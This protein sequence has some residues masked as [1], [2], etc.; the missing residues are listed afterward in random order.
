MI[1]LDRVA[2]FL[3]ERL[4]FAKLA[5]LILWVCY[6]GSILLGDGR[7]TFNLRGELACADHLAFY[8]AARL[9]REGQPEKVYDN[10]F[11]SQYQ[12]DMFP[13]RW[14]SLEAFRNPPFYAL[15]YYPTAGWPYQASAWFWAAVSAAALAVGVWWL[16]SA[17]GTGRLCSPNG[18]TDNSQGCQPLGPTPT[19]ASPNGAADAGPVAP[20]GLNEG[21][22]IDQGLTPLAIH[23]RPVGATEECGPAARLPFLPTLVWVISF[24]PVFCALSYGQNTPLSFA[25][26]AGTY[27]L[28]AAGRPFAAG[29]AA[30]LL[31]FK[32]TLLLGLIV[33]GLL[34]IRRLW[35]AAVG[36]VVTGA[37]LTLGSYP[38]VPELWTGFIRTLGE[39]A[40]YDN[41]EQWKMHNPLAFFRLL[42]PGLD[43]RWR[44]RLAAA[45]SLAV[46]GLFVR[47]WVRRRDDLP[48]VFGG[49]VFLTLLASPHALIYEWAL[50][51]I[52]GV[53]WWPET[54]RAP[55]R[56]FVVYVVVWVTMFLATHFSE[57]QAA[58]SPVVVQVSVP[59]LGWAFWQSVRLFRAAAPAPAGLAAAPAVVGKEGA[60]APAGPG[61]PGPAP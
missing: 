59:V 48:A 50:L 38:V 46:V 31:W 42:L 27:R 61:E 7:G 51:A 56:W 18:A 16:V 11:V 12:H 29:L 53:L 44:W 43:D 17:P 4:I 19:S 21:G 14:N 35:P 28:L 49:V 20:P 47:L 30:G 52:T 32:P 6:T 33:W 2:A 36:A 8:T 55:D 60:A 34:D 58:V 40:G 57:L 24:Y 3:R 15:L 25:V 37:V 13:E 9:V 26:F 22:T 10:E 5:T 54:R 41:F 39:N 1:R 23:G 45:V